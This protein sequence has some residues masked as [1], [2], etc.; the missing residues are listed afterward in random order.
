M[1]RSSYTPAI[2]VAALTLITPAAFSQSGVIQ[3][4]ITDQ[5]GAVITN[6][7]V[8]ALD[9]AKN[10]IVRETLS[11]QD[12]GFQLRPL[13]PGTYTVKAEV[14]GFK[15]LE[16]KGLVL[17]LNHIMNLG[18]LSL[19]IGETT[20]AVTVAADV[21]LVETSTS[22]KS[23]V[24]SSREVTEISLNGR[25]FQT[26][27]RTLPGVVSN[28]TSDFRLAFNN[29]DSFQT[30]GLRGSMNNVYL[31]GS[32]NTD[33]G[34]N[35]GQ[36]TQVS[37][38]AIGE[39][40]VQS[41]VF[42][43]EYG[44]NAGVLINA[45]V[46][47]GGSRFHGTG[48]EFL[49][50][51]FFDAN[52]FFRNLQGQPRAKLRFDQFGGNL[53]GPLYL[54][55]LS[56]PRNKRLFFFFNYEGTRAT[57]PNGGAFYDVYTST[58]LGGDLRPL[59]RSDH[60]INPDTKQDTGFPVGTVFQP[61]TVVRSNSGQIIG[62]TPFPDNTIPA[63]MWSKNA[64]AFLKVLNQVPRSTGFIPLANQPER[65]R[66]PFQDSYQFH[67]DQ[68]VARL[69]Y[70]ISSKMSFFFRWADDG[71]SEQQGFGIF[72]GNAFP[73]LPQFREKPGASWSWN[74]VNAISPTTTNEFIF[75]YNHLTQLVDI[76]G[77]VDPATYDR[78]KLGFQ[79]KELYPNSNL[80]NR[81]PSFQCGLGCAIS[82]F[83]PGWLSEGKTFAWTDNFSKIHGPHAFKTGVFVNMNDN[84]QQPSWTDA[85]SLNFNP[86]TNNPNDTGNGLANLLL[87]NYSGLSQSNGYFFGTF[88]FF[89]L[90]VYGQDSWKVRRNLTLEIGA[91]Y[92]Y[93]GPT[94]TYGK[95]LENY[96]DPSRYDPAKAV[97]LNTSSNSGPLFGS[98]IPG[99]GDP[100]N[101]LVEE[102]SQGIPAG[103]SQHRK[104][105]VSPRFGF[106]WDPF[107]KG[108]TSIRGGFG[109]FYER[110]RQNN[111]NFDGLGNPPLL[112]TP[113]FSSGNVDS[114]GPAL[115]ASGIR[116]PVGLRTFNKDGFTPTIYSWSFGVQH[117]LGKRTSIDTAYVGNT[118]RHLQVW[119]DINQLPLGTTTGPN[120]PLPA[121]NGLSNAI[122][123]YKGY[124]S[125]LFTDYAANSNYHAWQTRVSRRFAE[126]LTAN[127]AYTWGRAFDQVDS[128]S[129]TIGYYLDRRRDY[130]PAGFDRRSV[131]TADY[132][133]ELPKIGNRW[134][135][136]ALSR[137]LLDGWQFSGITRFWSGPPLD[138]TAGATNPGTLGGGVRAD[139]LGGQIYPD[140]QTREQ[141]FNPFVFASPVN[142][143]L[144]NLGRNALRRPGINQWDM[145][146]FKHTKVTERIT[147]QLRLE[148][149]N[150]F[151]HTQFAGVSSGITGPNPGQAVTTGSVGTSGQ[152]TS[153]RDPR[154]VQLGI[155][156]YF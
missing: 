59:L 123:P 34:A 124:T 111:N 77:D 21:P 113:N 93:L 91:R 83:P 13:L 20:E 125:I 106:A 41:S 96:F 92:V 33:V 28:D 105:Q 95:Y 129:T 140:H 22:Q 68:K 43:A 52:N 128:D 6:V 119:M 152:V 3:G 36:Y 74:L 102:N 143:T 79:F 17:D 31:D 48:Y 121:V 51:D 9:E 131:F 5:Q 70:N 154:N 14:K 76:E 108:K 39:F 72:S 26:L 53:S 82:P 109:I 50:N 27:M 86:S 57:R 49:R 64:P 98:I 110:I 126:G 151:N 150:T 134:G 54:P 133:Y 145:S 130:S 137:A 71:Q 29:T 90:E 56:T 1:P 112:Y 88:R 101:G 127:V 141:W 67:K 44:R 118:T 149:F 61:G 135:N 35:D 30:N 80:H 2:L 153:T 104:N 99:S 139:Y 24:I 37:L 42:N 85:I 16:R 116:S 103:F 4:T 45:N 7:K 156:V 138:V 58:V 94:Y 120:S 147:T 62:G 69:D 114:V 122:R 65:L 47:S 81:L 32:I 100:F 12:G 25:D 19:Q 55:K 73:V 107:G 40:K 87:G 18:N 10:I 15:A 136:S 75:T 8:S 142:G 46:K 117:E 115:I 11:G 155:K 148:T 89:G 66:I 132:V 97:K 78:D 144:G 146:L 63:S 23:F 38:D 60:I 84:G